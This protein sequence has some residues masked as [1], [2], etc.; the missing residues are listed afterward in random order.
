[1][2]LSTLLQLCSACIGALGSV[3]FTIGTVRQDASAMAKLSGTYW[4][5]NPHMIT[6]LAEQRAD[7]ILVRS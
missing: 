7:Y 1:M 3:F 5:A 4:T 2:S 6:T